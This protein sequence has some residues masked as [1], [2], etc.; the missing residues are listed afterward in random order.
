MGAIDDSHT[1]GITINNDNDDCQDQIVATN[2]SALSAPGSASASNLSS[3][4]EISP[5]SISNDTDT[6]ALPIE[7]DLP[8]PFD[9]VSNDLAGL[10]ALSIDD[11]LSNVTTS[12]A[13]FDVSFYVQ[14]PE[15]SIVQEKGD[16]ERDEG[17][18]GDDDGQTRAEEQR[19]LRNMVAMLHEASNKVFGSSDCMRFEYMEEDPKSECIPFCIF[20]RVILLPTGQINN[21]SLL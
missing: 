7:Q 10:G 3:P 19:A 13:V 4:A 1:E 14:L 11:F 20:I 21:V 18:R 15:T 9:N 8:R 12:S 16:I 17:D 6:L 2:L 5:D